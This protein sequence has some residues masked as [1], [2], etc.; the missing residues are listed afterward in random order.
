MIYIRPMNSASFPV[1][2]GYLSRPVTKTV[3]D[4]T[5]S[6]KL[7]STAASLLGPLSPSSQA[8]N[9][10]ERCARFLVQQVLAQW[11]LPVL[12][13]SGSEGTLKI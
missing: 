5:L 10:D 4:W 2:G 7:K 3:A 12:A 6:A 13:V 8:H 11:V 9:V 1:H